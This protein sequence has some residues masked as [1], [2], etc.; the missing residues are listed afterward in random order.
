MFICLLINIIITLLYPFIVACISGNK[1]NN[2]LISKMYKTNNTQK[3]PKQNIQIQ[4]TP[5]VYVPPYNIVNS[6]QNN[7]QYSP[8]D[9]QPLGPPYFYQ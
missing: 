8:T 4:Y 5:V 3:Y 6:P 7:W 9:I 2:L 1:Y